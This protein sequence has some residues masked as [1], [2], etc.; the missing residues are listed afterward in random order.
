MCEAQGLGQGGLSNCGLFSPQEIN[1]ITAALAEELFEKG[2][3]LG[4]PQTVGACRPALPGSQGPGAVQ[5]SIC[6]A[7]PV[8]PHQPPPP[9][10]VA[11]IPGPGPQPSLSAYLPYRQPG[12][13]SCG[14]FT[15][16]LLG[17]HVRG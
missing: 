9:P 6:G 12:L 11:Q 13:R 4:V 15:L 16:G 1:G 5:S 8:S 7:V 14:L 3:R 10:G 17:P 2:M